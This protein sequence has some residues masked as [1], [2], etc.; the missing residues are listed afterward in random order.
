MGRQS[1]DLLVSNPPYVPA[2]DKANVQ[3]EVRDWEPE[4]ALY[5]GETATKCTAA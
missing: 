5:G 1:L 2:R 4:I 3:R